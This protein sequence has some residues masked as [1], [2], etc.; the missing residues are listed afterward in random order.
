M[1]FI[2][3][4]IACRF[5]EVDVR[6]L[7]DILRRNYFRLDFKVQPNESVLMEQTHK[8]SKASAKNDFVKKIL[9]QLKT[10]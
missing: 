5:D 2:K 6:P 1:G 9:K 7:K 8:I 10:L 4:C 3:I